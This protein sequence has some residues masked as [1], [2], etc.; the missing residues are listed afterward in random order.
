MSIPP[1]EG[2]VRT[3]KF[4]KL[5]G[6]QNSSGSLERIGETSLYIPRIW[7]SIFTF[8]GRILIYLILV[9]YRHIYIIPYT[10]SY[11]IVHLRK[12][13]YILFNRGKLHIIGTPFAIK[14]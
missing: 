13:A 14:N 3:F 11:T 8:W 12:V 4:P 2:S 5:A 10:S 7:K 1:V 6:G 9:P